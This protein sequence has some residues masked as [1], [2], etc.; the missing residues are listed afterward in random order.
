[1]ILAYFPLPKRV[2]SNADVDRLIDGVD[3][4]C[5][6]RGPSD[7]NVSG[8]AEQRFDLQHRTANVDAV[9]QFADRWHGD[10]GDHA[11]NADRDSE[12]DDGERV[13]HR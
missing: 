13:S 11:Q 1:V 8:T 2:D 12:L 6:L 9:E 4:D 7:R 10:G 5:R 3:I